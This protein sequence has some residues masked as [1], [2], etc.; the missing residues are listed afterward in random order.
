MPT[1]SGS[2]SPQRWT[3]YPVA[4]HDIPEDLHLQQYACENLKSQNWISVLKVRTTL[5]GGHYI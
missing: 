2:G 5:N 3:V 4:C 1:L